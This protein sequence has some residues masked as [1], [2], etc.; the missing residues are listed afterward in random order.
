MQRIF[1]WAEQ[2][3]QG[4]ITNGVP[5]QTNT[6][7]QRSYPGATVT[8]YVGGTLLPATIYADNNGTPLA[9]PF[10]ASNTGYW[11]FYGDGPF[12]IQFSGSNIATPFT[13]PDV[14]TGG[15]LLLNGQGGDTQNFLVGASGNNFSVSSA[16]N[17]H[18]FNL[19]TASNNNR[20]ALSAG[21]WETFNNKQ[22][23]LTFVAPLSNN[24]NNVSLATPLTILYG[25]SNGNNKTQA[26][27][28]LAPLTTKG[29]LAVFNNN[30]HVVRLPVGNNNDVLI[31][32]GSNT[33]GVKWGPV[34]LGNATGILPIAN[35]G[36]NAN[37]AVVA[38]T[39]LSPITTKGDLIVGNNNAI[40]VR[41][42]SGAN[43]QVI[44]AD[45]SNT[46]GM[47]WGNMNLAG[48][49]V[50]G[51]LPVTAGGTGGNNN[52]QAFNLLSPMNSNGDLITRAANTG[53][54]L[55][56]GANNTVLT[57]NNGA[58]VWQTPVI[59]VTKVTVNFNNN[60]F[61]VNANAVDVTL[62]TLTQYQKVLGVTV[63]PTVLFI[64]NNSNGTITGIT[65]SMG[66]G[67]SATLFSNN[68]NTGNGGTTGNTNFQDTVDFKSGNMGA[69]Q[70]VLAHFVAA[71]NNF[72]NGANTVLSAGSLDVW[73]SV[74]N[75]Q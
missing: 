74:L 60:A 27:D 9:N 52:A 48:N 24:N 39:N 6:P 14:N 49:G 31:G 54:V 57:A 19:P 25:G 51:I 41:L 18:T 69:N 58:P 29:D 2:G 34:P 23:A 36:S 40:P 50:T 7:V 21:D 32:D 64:D 8:V 16:N 45:S 68:Y 66:V 28:N 55:A 30:N 75:L 70:A 53:A 12:D 63:K 26:F 3:N 42:G 59:L 37:T 1:G 5:S 67:G 17:N 15:I 71:S 38:F 44:I 47:A 35:G 46:S 10:T 11:D 65:V 4:V 73:F 22:D 61:I 43:N 13:L 62:F 33:S 72:G 56:I 20:G